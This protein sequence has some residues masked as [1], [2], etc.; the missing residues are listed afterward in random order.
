MR[1]CVR[2]CVCVCVCVFVCT[3]VCV[4]IRVCLHVHTGFVSLFWKTG[5]GG[6]ILPFVFLVHNCY[7][8][9]RDLGLDS[10][11]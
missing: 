8:F 9:L 7:L 10:E 5:C 2:A 6:A 1:A 4:H 3:Y 11:F